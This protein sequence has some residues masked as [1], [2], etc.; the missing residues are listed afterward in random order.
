MTPPRT[1]N[2]PII[3]IEEAAKFGAQAPAFALVLGLGREYHLPASAHS[4]N[5]RS[6]RRDPQTFLVDGVVFKTPVTFGDRLVLVQ[7]TAPLIGFYNAEPGV[8]CGAYG[9]P[10][11]DRAWD[12]EVAA[13]FRPYISSAPAVVYESITLTVIGEHQ[14]KPK[15]AFS[16]P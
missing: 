7:A 9:T 10:I 13:T 6:A 11:L 8:F 5:V 16:T 1:E 12:V 4:S 15:T 2:R 14:P 3:P